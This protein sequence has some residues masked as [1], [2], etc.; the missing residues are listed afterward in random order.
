MPS[1][2]PAWKPS[3]SENAFIAYKLLTALF[4]AT[5]VEVPDRD[6][7]FDLDA[8][9]RAITPRTRVIFIANPNNP[10]GTLVRQDVHR[11]LHRTGA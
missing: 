4:G 5:T 2:D 1:C 11:P 3:T 9:L 6:H 10:T 8:M 7:R